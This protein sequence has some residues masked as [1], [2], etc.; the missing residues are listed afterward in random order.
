MANLGTHVS[1]K[2]T[3]PP[4]YT[5]KGLASGPQKKESAPRNDYSD[6]LDKLTTITAVIRELRTPIRVA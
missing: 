3:A 6:S 4:G 5:E 2:H 1:W